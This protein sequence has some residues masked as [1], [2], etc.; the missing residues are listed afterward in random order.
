MNA[1]EKGAGPG[2]E[3]WGRPTSGN[4]VLGALGLPDGPRQR[5]HQRIPIASRSDDT[6]QHL[7][8]A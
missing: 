6:P 8:A 4:T 2:A 3:A 5:L 1:A 7:G